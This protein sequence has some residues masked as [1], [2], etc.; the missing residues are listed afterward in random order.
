MKTKKLIALTLSFIIGAVV[1]IPALANDDFRKEISKVVSNEV[2]NEQLVNIVK[3]TSLTEQK[4]KTISDAVKNVDKNAIRESLETISPEEFY[5]NRTCIETI[6][7]LLTNEVQGKNTLRITK[8]K[9]VPEKGTSFEMPRPVYEEKVDRDIINMF[10]NKFGHP[11]NLF[12]SY[13]HPSGTFSRMTLLGYVIDVYF[14]NGTFPEDDDELYHLVSLAYFLIKEGANVYEKV[15]IYPGEIRSIDEYTTKYGHEPG[16]Y[17]MENLLK[18]KGIEKKGKAE[19]VFHSK[20][21]HILIR[22]DSTEG[23]C[24]SIY[25]DILDNDVKALK[26]DLNTI[27]IEKFYSNKH[28]ID[29]IHELLLQVK[30]GNNMVPITK[31]FIKKFGHPDNLIVSKFDPDD[32]YIIETLLAD[33]RTVFSLNNEKINEYKS[34]LIRKGANTTQKIIRQDGTQ[35]TIKV[36]TK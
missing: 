17:F 27:T 3:G 10:I 21:L 29:N 5:T 4:C 26:S 25:N 23:K 30:E 12:V 8:T 35:T 14:I 13:M 9:L 16:Q 32:Q 11:D 34:F 22:T 24:D 19:H 2:Q 33:C 1:S 18:Q 20:L 28:C 7:Q 6:P 36:S 31:Q 15:N